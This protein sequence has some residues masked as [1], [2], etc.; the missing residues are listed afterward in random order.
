MNVLIVYYS[1]TGNT[2]KVAQKIKEYCE[3][4]KASVEVCALEPKKSLKPD[5]YSRLQEIEF[6]NKLPGIEKFD[7]IFVGS[8]VWG[9]GATPI[10]VS[11]LKGLENAKGKKFAVFLSCHVMTG[12]SVKK[13][14]SIL[15]TKGAIVKD[16]FALKSLLSIDEKKL[17][18][19]REFCEKVF[20]SL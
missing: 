15:A 19:T 5:E 10:I 7:L 16:S 6:K 17:S 12:N 1:K 20:S 4:K 14:S 13:M 18:K 11:Y 2:A 9:M 8:P 3:E